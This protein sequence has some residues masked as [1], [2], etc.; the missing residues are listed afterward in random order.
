MYMYM[1][2]RPNDLDLPQIIPVG[3]SMISA[4]LQPTSAT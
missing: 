2:F 3:K 4:N 1:K